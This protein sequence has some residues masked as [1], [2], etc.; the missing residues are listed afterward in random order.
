MYWS[1]TWSSIERSHQTYKRSSSAVLIIDMINHS[2]DEWYV[3]HGPQNEAIQFMDGVHWNDPYV[4]H[5][6]DH[7]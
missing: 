3:D 4:D 6:S 2:I 7:Q 5:G 1:S